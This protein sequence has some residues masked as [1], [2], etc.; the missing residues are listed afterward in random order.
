MFIADPVADLQSLPSSQQ[1]R[2]HPCPLH[3]PLCRAKGPA[4]SGGRASASIKVSPVH[5]REV[6][7]S[8]IHKD[9]FPSLCFVTVSREGA[10][11]TAQT[12]AP[13]LWTTHGDVAS[14]RAFLVGWNAWDEFP[15]FMIS[16]LPSDRAALKYSRH[17]FSGC[18][19]EYPQAHAVT[20][21]ARVLSFSSHP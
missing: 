16:S 9:V 18:F 2:G 11:R 1:D 17:L 10:S 3:C 12:Q 20:D 21:S 8:P 15:R 14:G 6:L 19:A 5:A 13:R 4:R 7:F